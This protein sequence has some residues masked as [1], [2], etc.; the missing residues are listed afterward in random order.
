MLTLSIPATGGP[1][2]RPTQAV[3]PG[4][5]ASHSGQQAEQ[6]EHQHPLSPSQL[7]ASWEGGDCDA[8]QPE[9]VLL[10]CP[11]TPSQGKP[12]AQPVSGQAAT[13]LLTIAE[14]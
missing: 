6:A 7:V 4:L 5:L 9:L 12:V 14:M 11:V 8:A 1:V 13:Q 2:T 10:S 3:L